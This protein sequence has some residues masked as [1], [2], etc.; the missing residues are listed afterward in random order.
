MQD[1]DNEVMR[2]IGRLEGKVDSLIVDMKKIPTLEKRVTTLEKKQYGIF[3]VGGVIGTIL[4]TTFKSI[5]KVFT[6]EG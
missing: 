3:L 2:A 5:A 1:N 4:L 6:G